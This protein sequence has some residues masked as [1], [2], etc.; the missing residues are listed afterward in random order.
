M[1]T[2]LE[3]EWKRLLVKEEKMLLSAENK[4]ETKLDGKIKEMWGKIEERI[5]AKLEAALKSAF[6]KAFLLIF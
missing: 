1:G 5:P 4:K 2:A 3:K 6:Y